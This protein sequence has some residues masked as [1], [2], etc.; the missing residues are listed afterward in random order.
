MDVETLTR[1]GG[2]ENEERARSD[3]GWVW[4][5][6]DRIAVSGCGKKVQARFGRRAKA[7]AHA[8]VKNHAFAMM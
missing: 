6:V 2:C 4:V 5:W 3:G 7:A 8:L 1:W